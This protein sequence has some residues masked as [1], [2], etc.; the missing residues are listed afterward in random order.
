MTVLAALV[1]LTVWLGNEIDDTDRLA[2]MIPLPLSCA[3]CGELGASSLTVRVPNRVPTTVGVNVTE[4]E[5]FAFG[6]RLLGD[7]GQ[8]E[9]W[10]KSPEVEIAPMVRGIV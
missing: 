6:G 1:P 3:I 7:C 5:Q 4:I 8:F 10:T 2:G 9:D